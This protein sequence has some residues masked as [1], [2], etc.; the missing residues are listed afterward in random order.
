M[1]FTFKSIRM[2]LLSAAAVLA[3]AGGAP[4]HAQSYPNKAVRIVVPYPPGGAVDLLARLLGNKFTESLG[5][6]FI[7]D[8]RPGAGGNIGVDVVA[9]AAPDGYTILINTNGTAISPALYS[10]LPY[11]VSRDLLPVTQIVATTLVIVAAPRL[12]VSSIR[13]LITAAKAKPGALNYGMTGVGNPL[14]LTMEMLKLAAGIDIVAVAY[15]GD[16]PLLSALTVGEVDLAVVPTVT[17]LPFIQDARLKALAVTS[18]KRNAVMAD[19]P[20]VAENGV[21]GFESSSWQ[22]FFLPGRAPRDIAAVIQRETKKALAAPDVMERLQAIA[23]DPV[24][25]TPEEFATYFA[26]E[27]AKFTKLVKEAHIP[28]QN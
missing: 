25:S 18:A 9:K 8:N 6:P 4:A 7:I 28:L 5:Q 13:D 10:N 12:P 2:Y 14:H 22:A 15:K 11:D 21:P 24:A 3:M 19:I 27:V 20:T 16:A 17:S 1:M 26:A 23:Y